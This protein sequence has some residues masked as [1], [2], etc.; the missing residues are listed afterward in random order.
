MR[1]HQPGQC[2]GRQRDVAANQRH[3]GFGFIAHPHAQR[4]STKAAALQR[5]VHLKMTLWTK[6]DFAV[7][8]LLDHQRTRCQAPF[9][10]LRMLPDGDQRRHRQRAVLAR[11]TVLASVTWAKILCVAEVGCT[12]SANT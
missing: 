4:R 8:G 2:I 11:G 12:P 3:G 10:R 5:G 1:Q 7:I 9:Q 6:H